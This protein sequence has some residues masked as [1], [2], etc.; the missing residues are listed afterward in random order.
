MRLIS[1]R[2]RSPFEGEPVSGQYEWNYRELDAKRWA[3]LYGVSYLEPRG[4]VY[5]EPEL[6]AQACTAAKR[7]GK[8]QE[9]SRLLF[10]AIFQDS[11]LFVS[12][13]L[14]AIIT[15]KECIVAA[16]A[17]GISAR[18]FEVALTEQATTEST[19]SYNYSSFGCWN[20]W[21]ANI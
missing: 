14:P 19:Q 3:K 16:E 4:R 15:A 6:L 17:C 1:Q 18:D 10:A 8:V 12:K 13:A 11:Q 2:E 21:C 5:F 7:L 9:Y 20:I